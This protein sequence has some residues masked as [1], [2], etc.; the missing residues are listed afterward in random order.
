V[1]TNF[2]WYRIPLHACLCVFVYE[3]VCVCVCVWSLAARWTFKN[4]IYWYLVLQNI[5]IKERSVVYSI[6]LL[7]C[8][9][10]WVDCLMDS[11]IIG[12]IYLSNGA[13]CDGLHANHDALPS[14]ASSI[15]RI[16]MY[17]LLC[18]CYSWQRFITRDRTIKVAIHLC[19]SNTLSLDVT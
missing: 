9:C 13:R 4:S 16:S 6:Q 3:C 7:W 12:R 15:R 14:L 10:D 11:K 17:I 5:T 1:L 19:V 2:S 8:A 18:Y